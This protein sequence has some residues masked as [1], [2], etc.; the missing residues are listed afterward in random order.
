MNIDS[1]P[2]HSHKNNLFTFKCVFIFLGKLASKY[3]L[4][5]T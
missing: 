5:P 4:K 1:E 3:K 2:K